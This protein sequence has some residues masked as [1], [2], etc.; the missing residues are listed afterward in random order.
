MQAQ[1]FPEKCL[2][3]KYFTEKTPTDSPFHD[4]RIL[5]DYIEILC[6]QKPIK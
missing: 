2:A 1:T 5:L 3:V 6:Q 4:S